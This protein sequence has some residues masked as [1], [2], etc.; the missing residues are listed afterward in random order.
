M[1]HISCAYETGTTHHSMLPRD[2]V[3][4]RRSDPPR[5]RHRIRRTAQADP[6]RM[7]DRTNR[8]H[9][10]AP[11]WVA[12]ASAST[13]CIG[14]RH[15][16]PW[17]SHCHALCSRPPL[18]CQEAGPAGFPALV[19]C[20]RD[21]RGIPRRFCCAARILCGESVFTTAW[22]RH[23]KSRGVCR[24]QHS[25]RIPCPGTGVGIFC[26]AYSVTCASANSAAYMPSCRGYSTH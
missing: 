11:Y 19:G 14:A 7:P 5:D 16:S 13:A 24:R 3:R 25:L 1:A 23:R 4:R 15:D 21:L 26:F 20:S 12:R 8:G 22:F 18:L 17:G 9:H 2:R 6:P 10:A